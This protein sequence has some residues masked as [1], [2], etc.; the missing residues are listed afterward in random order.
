LVLAEQFFEA[1]AT[2][3]ELIASPY[4]TLDPDFCLLTYSGP[5]ASRWLVT[6]MHA[7]EGEDAPWYFYGCI[8]YNLDAYGQTAN[9]TDYGTNVT[10]VGTSNITSHFA[11]QRVVEV[12]NGDTVIPLWGSGPTSGAVTLVAQRFTMTVVP[13]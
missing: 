5:D 8:A 4:W 10:Q 1:A 6:V 13:C 3:L 12:N 2:Y 7:Y 9:T 11:F